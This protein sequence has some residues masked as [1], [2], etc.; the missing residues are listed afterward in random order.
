MERYIKKIRA[1]CSIGNEL[2]KL[3]TCKRLQVGAIIFPTDC[4]AIYA[5]GYNGPARGLPNDSCTEEEGH[6]VCV[7][8]EA[9]AIIKFQDLSSKPSLLFSTRLPCPQ[10]VSFILNC[11]SIIGVIWDK[12]YRDS[13]GF[14]LLNQ[15]DIGFAQLERLE[16]LPVTLKYWKKQC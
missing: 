5:I 3:S 1:I 13:K 15:T 10:C 12:L 4:S 8:A 11:P 7:H 14:D 9:N 2:A 16:D 6:C